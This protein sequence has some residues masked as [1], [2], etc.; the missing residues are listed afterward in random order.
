[1]KSIVPFIFLTIF[2]GIITGA[3]IYL[4]H[5]FN[6]YFSIPYTRMLYPVFAVLALF[7]MFGVF[8]TANSVSLAGHIIY[9]LAAMT[10][11]LMLYLLISVILTDILRLFTGFKPLTYGLIVVIL[12]LGIN[13][14]GTLNSWNTK[15]T[16]HTIPI[17]GLTQTVRAMH[18]SDVHLGHFR[19]KRFLHKLVSKTNAQ[20]PDIVFI[21]GDLF[22]GRYRL[23]KKDLQPLTDLKAPVCFI[24]GNHDKYTGVQTIKTM[25]RELGI[26]VLENNMTGF[27]DLQIIGLNHM[28]ADDQTFNVHT[29]NGHATIKS[30]LDK[31]SPDKSKPTV[32]LHHSPDGIKYASKH[33]V[34][35]YLSGHTHA[36]QLVPIKYIAAL[37]F[38]FNQGLH[39]YNGTTMFVSQGAG[40]FGPP[41]RLGT[42]SEISLLT[43]QPEHLQAE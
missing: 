34:D 38:Q 4:T 14:A 19:G 9:I 29:Q 18:L 10:M 22:D 2:L 32:L 13:L 36:G 35:L 30:T 6:W 33:G 3:V 26:Q 16:H 28:A 42:I 5:R 41:I 31:L 20:N 17:K 11:G 15:V 8:T 25:L 43:L 27:K 12:T 21:T 1:M 7:M 39:H 24:E 37:M 23:S 40:T